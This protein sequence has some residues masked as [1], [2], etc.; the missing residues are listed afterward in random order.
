M[1]RPEQSFFFS[2]F[3]FAKKFFASPA[4][5]DS[6]LVAQLKIAQVDVDKDGV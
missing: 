4:P 5:K 2:F 1:P 3:Y 6:I